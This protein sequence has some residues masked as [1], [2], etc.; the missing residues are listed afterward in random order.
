MSRSGVARNIP[1]ASESRNAARYLWRIFD[2][3]TICGIRAARLRLTRARLLVYEPRKFK[4]RFFRA[5]L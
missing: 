1:A 2:Q 5:R 3:R 4:A